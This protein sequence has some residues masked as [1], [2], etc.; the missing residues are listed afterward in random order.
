[1]LPSARAPGAGS[2]RRTMR[3]AGACVA[4][5]F[6]SSAVRHA[7]FPIYPIFRSVMSDDSF[8][9]TADTLSFGPFTLRVAQ[10]LLERDGL[11]VDLGGRAMDVLLALVAKANAIVSKQELMAKAWPGMVVS[12]GSLRYQITMLRQALDDGQDGA[13]YLSNVVGRG[14]CFVARITKGAAAPGAQHAADIPPVAS[15]VEPGLPAQPLELLGRANDL[16][17][18][19][20][21]LLK[22]RFVTI[23]GSGGV[24]K[25]T[26]A[27]RTG[28]DLLDD[29]D[30]A[31]VFV[32][33]S[34]LTDPALVPSAIASMLGLSVRSADPVPSLV[35]Y[36]RER[37]M[38]LI[39]DNC[40]HV[41]AAAAS[42]AGR[43]FQA[44]PRIHIL[45]TSREALRVQREHIHLL[46]P[47]A[48]PPDQPG[49]AARDIL[50]YPA[51]RLFVDRAGASGAM[52]ALS[53][54]DAPVIA[55][56][57][58]KL[59]GVALA[60]ELAARR[61]AA[62][63]LHQTAALLDE[64]LALSWLGQRTAQPRHQTLQATLDW[65]YELLDAPE[66]A[67]LCRLSVFVGHFSL[68]AAREVAAAEDLTQAQVVDA[69]ASLAEK[70]LLSIRRSA[71]QTQYRLLES[72]RAYAQSKAAADLAD[73]AARRHAIY[74][75]Q[76]LEQM[77]HKDDAFSRDTA[78]ASD[79]AD[80]GNVRAALAW[81]FERADARDLGVSL[82]L[83]AVPAFMAMSLLAECHD[84]SKRALGELTAAT[85]GSAAEMHLQAAVGLSQMFTRG[86]SDEV[87]QALE[88][89]LQVA[90]ELGDA[91][92]QVELLGR[93]QIF[94]E[95]IGDFVES[96]SHARRCAAV[97]ASIDDPTA[98]ATA[99][100]LV[101]LC[102]HLVG[103]QPRARHFLEAAIAGAGVSQQR[104]SI[105]SGF[106]FHNRACIALARTLWL[107]GNPSQAV[108]VAQRAV[109]EA[110]QLNHPVTL[111]IAL[112][113]AVSV[114]MW[115]GD[116]AQAEQDID[117]F[118]AFAESHSLTPYLAVG[119][120]VKGELAVKRGDAARGVQAIQGALIE[121]RESRYELLTTSFNITLA[122]GLNAIGRHDDALELMN[123][124]L[125][126]VHAK[127]DLY[128]L[129]ELLRVKARALSG[130]VLPR[131]IEAEDSL[132]EALEVSR[133]QGARSWELRV[134]MDLARLWQTAGRVREGRDLL[135]GVLAHYTEG[136]T[137]ADLQEA[138]RL[139]GEPAA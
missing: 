51:T 50:L 136:F 57:C 34:M 47:L 22:E 67:V 135:E 69:I 46:D 58:R 78:R 115:V 61:V 99:H 131:A 66:R 71:T 14:Y 3:P 15:A 77:A 33:F 75:R 25:T 83:A 62:Y 116:L 80:L 120:G 55:N 100:S 127:G 60:I 94:H 89:S 97:A 12:D 114:Y 31:V 24:G 45:A 76:R 20:A 85:R 63:G 7:A 130:A 4:C 92:S 118:I 26:V 112:I 53:D 23:V 129:P 106:D 48:T 41:I 59:D 109:E 8:F 138:G 104:S 6:D 10:R 18:I 13:R 86:H 79:L 87:R 88:R 17:A 35:A 36:L 72:T 90:E 11:P 39:L 103:D 124:T 16:A 98:Q 105:Y 19:A 73:A 108:V 95:R 134:A 117:R 49:L 2:V 42:L 27:I 122:E 96:L 132:R 110:R 91:R 137:T 123:D 5:L 52:T 82:A 54:D 64:R 65:S 81:C 113:W 9:E 56:I 30:G 38:L 21:Q 125:A 121:L 68:E 126:L 29:F 43:I 128:N 28:Q 107:Q 84:W 37:R 119:R 70:S 102:H 101:G 1:M 40:E 93:L 32:D 74:F 111:C 139:L 44:A 133:Q